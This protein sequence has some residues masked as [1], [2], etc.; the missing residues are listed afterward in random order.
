MG[1]K[2]R[3][4][5]SGKESTKLHSAMDAT[6][7]AGT[8]GGSRKRRIRHRSYLYSLLNEDAHEIRLMTLL[9]VKFSDIARV[10]LEK[11][12]FPKGGPISLQFE[13]LSYT[14]GSQENMASVFCGTTGFESISVTRKLVEALPYLRYDDRPRVLWID[15]IC[16]SQ[17]DLD[18][19]SS[20]VKRM[21]DIFSKATRVVVWLGPASDDSSLAIDILEVISSHI[22]VDWPSIN[23]ALHQQ[24]KIGLPSKQVST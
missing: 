4:R 17:Q 21:A 11:V 3:S 6:D 1:P 18:E 7:V 9:P 24:M 20:Q 14:C 13:A 23:S 8:H 22:T 10:T 15:A 16:V 2:K 12:S 5:P 19:R